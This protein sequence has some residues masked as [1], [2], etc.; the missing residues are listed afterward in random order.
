MGKPKRNRTEDSPGAVSS[1]GSDFTDILDSIDKKLSSVDARLSLVEVLH[2]E[3]KS[4]RESLEYSQK[5]VVELMA[6]NKVLRGI[7][8]QADEAPEDTVKSFIQNH[9]KLPADNVKNIG[10]HRV[11]C[12]GGQQPENQKP[13][14]I[15]AK[16]EH[17]KQKELVTRRGRE[18]R[19]TNFSVNDQFPRDILE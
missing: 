13:R 10:F 9:L 15:V 4:L 8:E 5:Q 18:L 6:E 19:G 11:H 16:F 14:P 3:F 2:N 7:L 1:Q 17:F 12:L